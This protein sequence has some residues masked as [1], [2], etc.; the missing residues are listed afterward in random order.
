MSAAAGWATFL[1][2]FGASLPGIALQYHQASL[3]D[4]KRRKAGAVD[5]EVSRITTAANK[6][7]AMGSLGMDEAQA[8][9]TLENTSDEDLRQAVQYYDEG[10]G[11][12]SLGMGQADTARV[13]AGRSLLK[14][15]QSFPRV[16]PAGG[17]AAQALAGTAPPPPDEDALVEKLLP[18]IAKKEGGGRFD[19]NHP[20]AASGTQ[21]YGAYGIVPK[22]WFPKFFDKYGLDSTSADD[23]R[24][25]EGSPALQTAMAKD[26][27]REGLRETKGDLKRLGAWWYGGA[28]GAAK[29]GTGTEWAPQK[30]FKRV[31]GRATREE[32]RMPS[33]GEYNEDFQKKFAEAGVDA[34]ALAG[35]SQAAP[36]GGFPYDNSALLE[37][38]KEKPQA[39]AQV[40]SQPYRDQ[41]RFVI[42]EAAKNPAV[43]EKLEGY[44]K[45]LG[46]LADD[47]DKKSEKGEKRFEAEMKA[48]ND[49]VVEASKQ[50]LAV[51]KTNKLAAL[52]GKGGKAPADQSLAKMKEIRL[53]AQDRLDRIQQFVTGYNKA[54]SKDDKDLLA[55]QFQSFVKSE[56]N[57]WY[58]PGKFTE[59]L[60]MAAVTAEAGRL[61][62]HIE[63]IDKEL[64]G[65][66]GLGYEEPETDPDIFKFMT[67]E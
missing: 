34:T 29:I 65:D 26:I 46:S 28:E 43:W 16:A 3:E 61:Q 50:A 11:D 15:L 48:W 38:I 56:R 53:Q 10:G 37:T 32:L 1:Q 2:Q 59:K 13:P 8:V 5:A 64:S 27:L 45:A 58:K 67:E 55:S 49:N 31:N 57:P 4:E 7:S 42:Q 40:R 62:R 63:A 30:A 41:Q 25:F 22:V 6:I 54:K 35:Y 14:P 24:R 23:I 18:V 21:A 66:V 9:K 39:P 17:S 20:Q 52:K 33:L 47:E 36:P 51:W 12:A 19:P 60:D 44:A